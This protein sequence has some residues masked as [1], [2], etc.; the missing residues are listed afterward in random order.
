M[1]S[2]FVMRLILSHTSN[3]LAG[4]RSHLT[5]LRSG[6]FA[7]LTVLGASAWSQAPVVSSSEVRNDSRGVVST[8][9]NLRSKA[10][11]KPTGQLLLDRAA[12]SSPE[13]E[14]G[15]PEPMRVESQPR[16]NPARQ[17]ASL[18]Q[19]LPSAATPSNQ[20]EY[21]TA[22]PYQLRAVGTDSR[23][24]LAEP[25]RVTP[26]SSSTKVDTTS[27]TATT[28]ELKAS[29]PKVARKPVPQNA[30]A[31][32]SKPVENNSTFS[33]KSP[34]NSQP[35]VSQPQLSTD[36]PALLP[37]TS[38][39]KTES[40]TLAL[41]L[42]SLPSEVPS[43]K[44]SLPSATDSSSASA[45]PQLPN[46]DSSSQSVSVPTLLPA[47]SE[48]ELKSLDTKGANKSA[49]AAM[50]SLPSKNSSSTNN[51][52]L[53]ALPTLPGS[54]TQLS[55]NSS[56]APAIQSGDAKQPM[57]NRMAP[58]S[59]NLPSA[60]LPS[61]N[62]P[63]A[64]LPANLPSANLP[65]ANR[66]L[67]NERMA[68]E[69]TGNERIKMQ[70]PRIQVTLN[71]PP[72][73][74]VGEAN[75]YT[76]V[77]RNEDK[78]NLAGIILRL[79]VPPGVVAQPQKATHGAAEI[80]RAQDGTTML[81]WTFENLEGNSEAVMPL[82]VV[83]QQP[84]NFAV[85]MEWTLL[86]MASNSGID[87]LTPQLELAL[88][89]PNEVNFSEPNVF[90]LHVRNRGN[91]D[92]NDVAVKLSAEH[93]GSSATEIGKIAA[94]GQQTVDVEL[95]FNEPGS[96]M[97]AAEAAAA[98]NVAAASQVNVRVRQ[99]VL[100]A[101]LDAPEIVYH[102]SPTPY[103]LHV[104]NT[105]DAVAKNA[106]A[107]ITLPPDCT[108]VELPADATL[109]NGSIVWD[110]AQLRPASASEL[111]F[112]LS[113]AREG[114]NRVSVHCT[115]TSGAP[116]QC[117]SVTMVKAV[118]DLK[119][120]VTDPVAPAPVNGEV[121]YELKLVNRGSKAAEQVSVIALF[122]KDIEPT[123]AEGQKSQI[124]T[125][126]VR[127]QPITRVE[128]GQTITLKVYAQAA[129]AGMHRFRAEV[130][131]AEADV[132]LVQEQSTEYMETIRR[133]ASSPSMMVR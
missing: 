4:G 61:A 44:N 124:L 120:F 94:G 5:L 29:A 43:L 50:G 110:L 82:Q 126:Q 113:F 58:P 102:S 23:A 46:L 55:D 54:S 2:L 7:A 71:G 12:P 42:P 10:S 48:A 11:T 111:S 28:E 67:G 66:S 33:T 116:V 14:L 52:D 76:L 121:Q 93:Y 105:G 63:S 133:T 89:G 31:T 64:N 38:S 88:E 9:N 129:T 72:Q 103:K 24:T 60:N 123:R 77:V 3:Q 109:Q 112:S 70:S 27:T 19:T 98:G 68:N 91:A 40:S 35:K 86:P 53:N 36:P 21:S 34:A 25:L 130:R 22:S 84:R 114:D 108:A 83:A 47:P 104:R 30:K 122:S 26:V 100:E 106:K 87:V 74:S 132:K 69:R 90:R 115:S 92:A 128:P 79:D 95:V 131:T 6:V 18:Q 117:A 96:I 41:D 39:N 17:V 8:G 16:S 59:A 13:L 78:I 57:V 37:L 81:T 118:S 73:L 85:A 97:I 101:L 62:L 127:F 119:L 15:D 99:S 32:P 56:S 107:V 65:P 49:P 75:P 51:L 80:E 20:P 1:R 45:F 125:G